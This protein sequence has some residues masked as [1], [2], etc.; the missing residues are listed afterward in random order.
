MMYGL[1]AIGGV[2]SILTYHHADERRRDQG[3][4]AIGGVTS[5]LTIKA[6]VDAKEKEKSQGHR[7]RYIYPD[8]RG[9]G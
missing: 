6:P 8:R 2:T 4:S 5:I 7:G 3:L 1:S 9:R